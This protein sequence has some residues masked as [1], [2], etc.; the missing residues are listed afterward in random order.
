MGRDAIRQNGL[1]FLQASR[2][3]KAAQ[4]TPSAIDGIRQLAAIPSTTPNPNRLSHE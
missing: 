3:R 2:A 1:E 4:N